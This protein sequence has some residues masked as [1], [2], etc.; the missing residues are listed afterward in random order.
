MA[1]RA[2]A[3]RRVVQRQLR[4]GE[5]S[6]GR[7]RSESSEPR[8]GQLRRARGGSSGF[9]E[10]WRRRRLFLGELTGQRPLGHRQSCAGGGGS[11]FVELTQ[12]SSFRCFRSVKVTL[13]TVGVP[14]SIS[15]RG[16]CFGIGAAPANSRSI[17]KSSKNP[18]CQPPQM[19]I[20]D[21][22]C[23]NDRY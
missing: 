13:K 20:S 16:G 23:H 1:C 12:G 19:R 21:V 10:P 3:S 15:C 22:F 7:R 17:C 14:S 9:G 6:K 18:N 8:D 5:L 11:G 2:R 4:L